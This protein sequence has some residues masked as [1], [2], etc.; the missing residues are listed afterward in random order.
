MGD[1]PAKIVPQNSDD[2]IP[3]ELREFIKAA[4]GGTEITRRTLAMVE[5]F[6]GPLPHPRILKQYGDVMPDAPQRIF[7]M[8]ENQQAHRI[9]LEKSVIKSDIHRAD[10]GLVLGFILFLTFGI[11]SIVLLAFG[12]DIQ[13]FVLLGTSLLG[14]IGNFIKV[15]RERARITKEPAQNAQPIKPPAENGK[16]PTAKRKRRRGHKK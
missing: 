3:E 7:C 1:E 2:E 10:T 11:G 14:G 12:K 5:R 16:N 13:G 4:G 15:G 8:A 9:D 6:S